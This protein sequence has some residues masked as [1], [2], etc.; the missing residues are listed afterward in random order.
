LIDVP[1]SGLGIIRKKPEIKYTK[2][3][4]GLR[5]LIDV[6]RKIMDNASNYVKSNGILLYSTCTVNKKKMKIT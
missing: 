1:C 6:Q 2:D 5:E 3:I 4:K